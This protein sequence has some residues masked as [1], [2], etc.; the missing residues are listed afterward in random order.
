MRL[1]SF[2]H[3]LIAIFS[4]FTLQPA[5]AGETTQSLARLSDAVAQFLETHFQ[6]L[7]N[8]YDTISV[9]VKSL[10]NRLTLSACDN[11]LTFEIRDT[12]VPGGNISVHT[13][14]S[15]EKPWSVYVPAHVELF[16]SI[17]VSSAN[18]P[19]GTVLQADHLFQKSL[20]VAAL[21]QPFASDLETLLGQQL[22]RPLIQG[23]PIRL[24]QLSA[25]LVIKRGDGILLEAVSGSIAVAANGVAL[26][27]GRIGEQ[28]RVKNEQSN[29]T[30]RAVAVAKGRAQIRF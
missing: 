8:N 21:H 15:N 29:Q 26:E 23:Q 19:K 2:C 30:V 5:N 18:L 17:W 24:N 28:I 20:N 6:S 25:P 13:Q 3:F 22:T 4:F 10:D 14:C 1:R 27:D 12:G 11:F 16:Q 7:P 9:K